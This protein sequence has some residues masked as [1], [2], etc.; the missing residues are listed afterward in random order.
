[1]GITDF[2]LLLGI[3]IE[4]A[5][6]SYFDYKLWGTLYTP[7]NFL[8]LPYAVILLFCVLVCG[9]FGVAEFY[10]PS[11]ILWMCGLLLFAVPG[12]VVGLACRKDIISE[13]A[14]SIE[15]RLPMKWINVFSFIILAL[16][17]LR[18]WRLLHTSPN[19]PGT[20]DFGVEFCGVGIWGHLHRLLHALVI[21][22]IYKYDK[23]HWYYALVVG[24]MFVVSFLYGVNSWVLIPA[25][26]GLAMRLFTG[27][28]KLK[29][30]LF[31]K[32][33][34][35]AFAVFIISYSLAL[36]LGKGD[37]AA[38]YAVVFEFICDIFIHYFIS[39]IVGWS[40][41]FQLG[42]LERPD[43][44]SVIACIVN[45]I[46]A[47]TGGGDFVEV[48]N[49]HFIYNGVNGSN[50]RAFFGTLYINTSLF[51]FIALVLIFSFM[52]YLLKIWLMRSK[53]IFVALVYFFYAGMLIMGWFEYYFYH[54]PFLEVPAWIFILYMLFRE[55]GG[56]KKELL[57]GG[58]P[59]NKRIL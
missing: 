50:V 11:L 13:G 45:L 33:F 52:M 46:K 29:L 2:I 23:K 31:L 28:M 25:M 59:E 41:D 51:E 4:I 49:P 42:I 47:F 21:L 58:E 5:V 24:A 35:F 9:N 3:Y 32:I 53:S 43:S 56:E 40:Q 7:L 27:K 22:Y 54:L 39:G 15:E 44:F 36:V 18:L 12:Y 30:S 26:G 34:I 17:Y 37:E 20:T 57:A 16:F 48:I 38:D 1:M 55:R 10:Y 19:L 14:R 8:M 6:L